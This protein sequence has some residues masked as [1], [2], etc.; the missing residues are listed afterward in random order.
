MF[1]T[2]GDNVHMQWNLSGSG[3]YLSDGRFLLRRWGINILENV[4]W[5]IMIESV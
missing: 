2:I 1:R 5:I 3:A 4:L